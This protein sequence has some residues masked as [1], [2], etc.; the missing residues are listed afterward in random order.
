MLGGDAPQALDYFQQALDAM[1]EGEMTDLRSRTI[2]QM[3]TLFSAQGL[4]KE[5]LKMRQESFRCDSLLND[6]IGLAFSLRDIGLSYHVASSPIFRLWNMHDTDR[7]SRMLMIS[8]A[9]FECV[10]LQFSI[11]YDLSTLKS[12]I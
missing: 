1:P 5:A 7:Q 6:S 3:G 2:S 10:S 9:E 12:P 4:Y 8:L 11:R